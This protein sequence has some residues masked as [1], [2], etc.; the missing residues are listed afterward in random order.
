MS[1]PMS[2]VNKRFVSTLQIVTTVLGFEVTVKIDDQKE[3]PIEEFKHD[4]YIVV[5][6]LAFYFVKRCEIVNYY[7]DKIQILP[8]CE[9]LVQIAHYPY[10]WRSIIANPRIDAVIMN[11]VRIQEK[12]NFRNFLEKF[13]NF[14]AIS[15]NLATAECVVSSSVSDWLLSWPRTKKIKYFKLHNVP[16]ETSFYGLHKFCVEKCEENAEVY[17]CISTTKGRVK[18]TRDSVYKKYDVF[19]KMRRLTPE[20]ARFRV[21]FDHEFVLNDVRHYDKMIRYVAYRENKKY[22]IPKIAYYL[23]HILLND[24][25][26]GKGEHANELPDQLV[27]K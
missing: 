19:L 5:T 20:T 7:I 1:G 22:L 10:D 13:S 14:T 16:L 9:V 17:I 15:I 3:I 24:E 25:R 2:V 23:D 4:D 12:I 26:I 8:R 27:L 18:T 11:K 21:F 6:Q